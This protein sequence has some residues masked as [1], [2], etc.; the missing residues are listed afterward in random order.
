MIDKDGVWRRMIDTR[1]TGKRMIYVYMI[2]GE[3]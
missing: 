2:R 1:V 3:E